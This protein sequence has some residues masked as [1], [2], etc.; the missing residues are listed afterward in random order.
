[1]P[2]LQ[3]NRVASY[4][5]TD[6]YQ[7]NITPGVAIKIP[8]GDT[9]STEGGDLEQCVLEFDIDPAD[10]DTGSAVTFDF[11]LA[12]CNAGTKNVRR[13]VNAFPV[14]PNFGDLQSPTAL[15][16]TTNQVSFTDTGTASV[17]LDIRD[18]IDDMVTNG[19]P[20]VVIGIRETGDDGIS[21][22]FNYDDD[23]PTLSYSLVGSP[24]IEGNADLDVVDITLISV[25]RQVTR[26]GI[27]VIDVA[28]ITLDAIGDSDVANEALLV[29][30][31]ITL[32]SAGR[33]MSRGILNPTSVITVLMD[34]TEGRVFVQGTTNFDDILVNL[35][36][37]NRST[38]GTATLYLDDILVSGE[39]PQGG[40]P[41]IGTSN[42]VI[43]VYLVNA[44]AGPPN[45]GQLTID[46]IIITLYARISEAPPVDAD[47]PFLDSNQPLFIGRRNATFSSLS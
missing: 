35:L 21:G 33:G 27:S 43:T 11:K 26:V 5:Y 16:N 31:P 7:F 3:V 10:I 42:P 22:F 9:E 18:M 36:S 17:S 37:N 40:V 4:D 45:F 39:I 20:K 44:Q 29:V 19:Q 23:R 2:T 12:G 46:P 1:M 30:E 6:G 8:F 32:L 13:W 15:A 25:G 38:E 14:F 24:T 47:S 41:R 34:N 28:D